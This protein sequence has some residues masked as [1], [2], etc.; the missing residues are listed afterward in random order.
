MRKGSAM[1]TAEFKNTVS[2]VR[3]HDEFFESSADNCL[4]QLSRIISSSYKRR[5]MARRAEENA[6]EIVA[7]NLTAKVLKT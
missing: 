1:V 6:V 2:I 3:I 7:A 4:S 5:Q